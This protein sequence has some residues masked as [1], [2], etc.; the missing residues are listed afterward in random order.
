MHIKTHHIFRTHT[1]RI[2][3]NTSSNQL[4]RI[5]LWTFRN[6][7]V[8][9]ASSNCIE[10]GGWPN[11]NAIQ[12]LVMAVIYHSHQEL[13]WY[14]VINVTMMSV[15]VVFRQKF[16]IKTWI[17]TQIWY[18]IKI[19][20]YIN[21]TVWYRIKMWMLQSFSVLSVNFNCIRIDGYLIHNVKQSHVTVVIDGSHQVRI[22]NLVIHVTM[23]S[24]WVVS[25]QYKSKLFDG[26]FYVQ[27]C[28]LKSAK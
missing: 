16:Q 10:I 3:T 2:R 6:S 20:I 18:Q 26:H 8:P 22:L 9:S 7:S 17:S 4:Y 23:T 13:I 21:S 28:I 24:V 12:L 14:L 5:T 15:W 19:R 27:S 25:L 1:I 11:H